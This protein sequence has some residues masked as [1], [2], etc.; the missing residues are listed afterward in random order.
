MD[1][2]IFQAL[3]IGILAYL[4]TLMSP[5][6]LGCIGGWYVVGRPLV[7]GLLI[8][9]I[10][11]DIQTGIIVGAAVQ[12]VFIAMVTPGGTMPTD[13]NAAAFIGVGLG[14]VA[15][16]NGSTIEAAVSIATAMGAVGIILHNLVCILNSGFNERVITAIQSGDEKVFLRNHWIF[17]QLLLLASRLIPT[18]MVLYYGQDVA[19]WIINTFPAESYV[20]RVLTVLGGL[21]PAI[22]VGLLVK[23]LVKD[24]GDLLTIVFGFTLVS[25]LGVNM[26]S[27]AI[28]A[29]FFAL[30]SYQ[31]SDSTPKNLMTDDDDLEEVL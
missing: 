24:L 25:A 3:L 29:G 2:N 5:W 18:F 27:L 15:V 23:N 16:R 8:G 21:F 17:P 14:I 10:L 19:A 11:G 22:G 4:G 7:S 9:V 28:I 30:M 13:L 1:I 26:V 31:K 20:M 6:L 12:T